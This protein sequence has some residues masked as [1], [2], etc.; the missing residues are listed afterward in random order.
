[1]KKTFTAKEISRI[2]IFTAITAVLA[3]IVVP[4]PFTPMPISFG[5]VAVYITGILLKP[6]HAVFVQICYL[7]IGAV[8]VPVF[9]NFRG[10]VGALF[11]PT[12]GY[13]MMYPIMAWIVSFA[14]NSRQSRQ[15]ESKQN[16]KWLFAKA[17]I[18][19]SIAHLLLYLG[20]TTWLCITTGSSFA[21]ALAL[22]VYPFIPLDILKIVFCV[23]AVIPLRFRMLSNNMLL[24]DDMPRKVS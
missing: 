14:L 7:L 16:K 19:I 1:M 2:A 6:K 17:G 22:A 13:L 24:L 9:G 20:G 18:S 8:G 5:L 3:Q 12:G 21:A 10:G 11:G 15:L 4:L 23:V